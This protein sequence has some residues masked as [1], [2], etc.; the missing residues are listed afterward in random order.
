MKFKFVRNDLEPSYPGKPFGW[1]PDDMQD[2]VEVRQ[3]FRSGKLQDVTFWKTGVEFE[4]PSAAFFVRNGDA[5]PADDECREA[6]GMTPVQIKDAQ[7]NRERLAQGINPEDWD[8]YD[9]GY[10]TGYAPDGSGKWVPGPNY[11]EWEAEQKKLQED[12]DI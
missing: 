4:H 6:C 2:R 10:M 11:A 3:V 7:G 9:K 5:E 8:A 12:D 1:V